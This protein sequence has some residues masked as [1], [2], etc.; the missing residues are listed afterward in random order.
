MK[1]VPPENMPFVLITRVGLLGLFAFLTILVWIAWRHR[2]GQHRE[3]P[4]LTQTR[5]MSETPEKGVQQ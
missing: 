4:D 2:Q 3:I 1:D 5:Q